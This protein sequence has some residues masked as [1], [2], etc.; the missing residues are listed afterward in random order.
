M[1]F[2]S[3][4]R[5]VSLFQWQSFLEKNLLSPLSAFVTLCHLRLVR[6]PF[7]PALHSRGA[8]QFDLH[9]YLSA[10]TGTSEAEGST[11]SGAV[12][13]ISAQGAWRVSPTGMSQPDSP[14]TQ[15]LAA[16]FA[17]KFKFFQLEAVTGVTVTPSPTPGPAPSRAGTTGTTGTSAFQGV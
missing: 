17:G 15:R 9:F 16:P 1:D 11:S 7:L 8:R 6:V 3:E 2:D 13:L 14:R 10:T 12:Q 4:I 5:L